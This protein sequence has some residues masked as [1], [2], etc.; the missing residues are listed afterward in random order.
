MAKIQK[1]MKKPVRKRK[2]KKLISN[3][4]RFALLTVLFCG[5]VSYA[6]LAFLLSVSEIKVEY[7][8]QKYSREEIIAASNIQTGDKIFFIN[9]KSVNQRIENTLPYIRKAAIKHE[10]PTGIKIVVTENSAAAYGLCDD[11]YVVISKE[12]KALEHRSF[13]EKPEDI[14]F[15]SNDVVQSFEIG[16]TV[17]FT[18]EIQIELLLLII[19]SLEEREMISATTLIDISDK[20]RIRFTYGKFTIMLG[21]SSDINGKIKTAFNTIA[22]LSDDD[23]GTIDVS[24]EKSTSFIPY[25]ND[26]VEIGAADE[27]IGDGEEELQD[28]N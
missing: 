27:S 14:P 5:I 15:L 26:V 19:N 12:G 24:N 23:S 18:E 20:F 17:S 2:R 1:E 21:N 3:A 22:K 25:E 7:N 11:G 28:E 16:Q 9:K 8:G 4:V 6:L 13:Y 10:I